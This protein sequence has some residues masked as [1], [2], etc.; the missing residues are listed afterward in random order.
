MYV[1]V[2]LLLLLLFDWCY[3]QRTWIKLTDSFGDFHMADHLFVLS[4]VVF[5]FNCWKKSVFRY[6]IMLLLLSVTSLSLSLVFIFA[7]LIFPL[8]LFARCILCVAAVDCTKA[9]ET[10]SLSAK[11]DAV[12]RFSHS[13]L[14]YERFCVLLKPYGIHF[15]WFLFDWNICLIFPYSWTF[16]LSLCNNGRMKLILILNYC[17]YNIIIVKRSALWQHTTARSF[18]FIYQVSFCFVVFRIIFISNF[19]FVWLVKIAK[20]TNKIQR[21]KHRQHVDFAQT[22]SKWI[23]L[24]SIVI[25]N[26][27]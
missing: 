16:V 19:L 11:R 4:L 3:S 13:T 2:S 6:D 17:I 9:A 12:E 7:H 1:C 18:S 20:F 26:K 8:L 21:K 25:A 10:N 14:W 23:R 15:G 5:K 27:K 22:W 24:N